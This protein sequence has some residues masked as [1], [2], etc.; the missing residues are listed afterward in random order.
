M[1]TF[2]GFSAR[3]NVSRLVYYESTNDVPE[4]IAREKQIKGY[5][6]SKKTALVTAANPRW[7][8]LAPEQQQD[9][10]RS[11]VVLPRDDRTLTG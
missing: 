8:K 5:R 3:Y 2:P 1:K 6:R 7:G 11:L 10:A 4:A 9:G